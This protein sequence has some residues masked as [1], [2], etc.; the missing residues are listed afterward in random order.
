MKKAKLEKSF[1]KR[2]IKVCIFS[3]FL[4]IAKTTYIY[5]RKHKTFRKIEEK[6]FNMYK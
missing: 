4:L 1:C 2:G 5:C 3:A 6:N